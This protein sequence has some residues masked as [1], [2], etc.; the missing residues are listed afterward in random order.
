MVA[1]GSIKW[2]VLG[3]SVRRIVVGELSKGQQ[4]HPVVLL[5]VAVEAQVLLQGLIDP[6]SLAIGLRMMS[7]RHGCLD[8]AAAEEGAPEM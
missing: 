3:G 5:I 4:G 7:S 1:I 6:F 2:G 8:V